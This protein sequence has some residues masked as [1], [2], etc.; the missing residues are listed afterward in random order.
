MK[1]TSDENQTAIKKLKLS[2]KALTSA[3]VLAG[4]LLLPVSPSRASSN[5]PSKKSIRDRVGLVRQTLKQKTVN[6]QITR[7]QA[8]LCRKGPGPVGKLGKLGKLGQLEQLE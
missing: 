5:P 6:D 1:I 2:L 4:A 8:Y 3:L 7:N